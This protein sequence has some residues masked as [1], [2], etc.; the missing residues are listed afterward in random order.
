[1]RNKIIAAI[2]VVIAIAGPGPMA[3][4]KFDPKAQIFNLIGFVLVMILVGTAF[5]LFNSEKDKEAH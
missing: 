5:F 4:M 2:L 3:Y 1:M